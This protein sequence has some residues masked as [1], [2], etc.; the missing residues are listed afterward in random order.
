VLLS[1]FF[2]LRLAVAQIPEPSD[3]PKPLEPAEAAE[4]IETLP[5]F[6][7]ELVASEP[8]I[9]EPSGVCWDEQGRLY[10]CELHGYNLE[11]QLEVDE[12]NKSG[13]LDTTVRR[14]QAEDRFKEAAKPGAYGVVKRLRDTDGDGRMDQADVL[15]D[16]LPP[17]YGLC[18][19]RGGLI[20]AC[21]PDIVFLADRDGDG[22]AEFRETLFTGF[23]TGMLERGINAPQWG[24][25]G[26]IYVGRGWGGGRITGPRLAAPVD[27]P[28]TDFRI[29]PD[30]SAIEPVLGGT[31]TIGHALTPEGDRFVT[32]T[33]KHSL[34]AA[35]I[36]WRYLARNP[37]AAYGDLEADAADYTTVFPLAP[38]HPWKLARSNQPGWKELYDAYGTSESAASGYFTSCCSPLVYQSEHFP[39]SCF[40]NLF[41]CEPAQSLIHRAVVERDGP[42]LVVR[43]APGEQRREFLAGRDSWFRPVALAEGPE[44][45]LWIVD[46]YREIIEDYSAVP[47]FMQQQYGVNNGHDRGR[48]WRLVHDEAPPARPAEMSRLDDAA[49]AA[50]LDSG[51]FWRR[52]TAQRLL[53]ERQG[54]DAPALVARRGLLAELTADTPPARAIELLRAH[55]RALANDAAALEQVIRL[56]ERT[57]D[58]RLLLQLAL[59]LGE[60]T[61]PRA[62][63]ALLRLAR[64][65]GEIRWMPAA[66]LSGA[67][68]RDR[69]MAAGLLAEPGPHG[70][71]TLESLSAAIAAR[72]EADG[73]EAVLAAA[74][75][76][77]HSAAQ[78]GAL[79]GL[80]SSL[81]AIPLSPVAK[82]SLHQ[83]LASDDLAV[84]GLAARIA[85]VLKLP[86]SPQAAELLARATSDLA[87]P[88]AA[89]ERRQAAVALLA[90]T[91]DNGVG[92]TLLTAWPS[93]TPAL[94]ATLVDALVARPNRV[95]AVVEALERGELNAVAFSAGHRSRLLERADSHLRARL[96][97]L[98]LTAAPP[99][100]EAALGRFQAAL[101]LERD[102]ER[103][104][105][106][107]EKHCAV[108]HKVKNKGGVVGPEL[109]QAFRR[110]EATLL[111]D[112][113]APSEKISSGY[114]AYV[115]ATHDGQQFQGVLANESATSVTLRLADGSERS[116]LRKDIESL[117]GSGVSLMPEGFAEAL[118]PQDCAD[119]LAWIKRALAE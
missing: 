35:P 61:D 62:T 4:A 110:D 81:E 100:F 93:A 67:C 113:L 60:S 117:V 3:A 13:H 109:S 73:I 66:I 44:G 36:P 39:A 15:A 23:P 98:F 69:A 18:P 103:G 47:R 64:E 30:G 40:G 80:L 24:P 1:G 119:L 105:P 51:S 54:D 115:V 90:L 72:R 75:A 76:S 41:V 99:N 70:A 33:W 58:A 107:F 50:E 89:V 83:L 52:Q 5:G 112:L 17:A 8:L 92:A 46:M 7:L 6:R 82:A 78:A 56:A 108:C 87:D 16:D 57:R 106:L 55:D 118:S 86:N 91:D 71:E 26:W 11:G 116:L 28:N 96:E 97:Q 68:R 25:D 37:D 42:A 12:L 34:Y 14:I 9:T 45:A 53:R 2:G 31:H 48:I 74:A 84:K 21:A 111:R 101:A 19:A 29:K 22:R 49:L 102:A 65:H 43:R 94:R 88:A 79:A 27:L 20:V 32:T 95:G 10:V 77:Q 104:G 114:D 38:V 63:K 59:S 85:A